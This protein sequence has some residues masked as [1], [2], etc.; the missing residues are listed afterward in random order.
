MRRTELFGHDPLDPEWSRCP[1]A[2]RDLSSW[3]RSTLLFH[4]G[5]VI[6]LVDNWNGREPLDQI[7]PSI[8]DQGWWGFTD[9]GLVDGEDVSVPAPPREDDWSDQEEEGEEEEEYEEREDSE[10]DDEDGDGSGPG[11]D[12]SGQDDGPPDVGGP[13]RE[14]EAEPMTP[15]KR[16]WPGRACLGSTGKQQGAVSGALLATSLM[17]VV[18]GVASQPDQEPASDVELWTF[19][20]LVVMLYTAVI[21]TSI[22]CWLTIRTPDPQDNT[23]DEQLEDRLW[24]LPD[25]G[26]A[27]GGVWDGVSG[28]RLDEEEGEDDSDSW[29]SGEF[30][31]ANNGNWDA[32]SNDD[33]GFPP[34]FGRGAH[35]Q[36]SRIYQPKEGRTRPNTPE[37]STLEHSRTRARH[38]REAEAAQASTWRPSKRLQNKGRLEEGGLEV[39]PLLESLRVRFLEALMVKD[40]F[41]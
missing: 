27:L 7:R 37:H 38:R 41:M 4:N 26:N 29:I 25:G 8:C 12:G 16:K 18:T 14:P 28:Q 2:R 21:I 30:A 22:A 17:S 33:E 13:A 5:D 40:T 24:R 34:P 15:A 1:I 20:G 31:F 36:R 32:R 10:D 9:F 6:Y 11:D 3:R 23:G 35:H 19:G 39:V